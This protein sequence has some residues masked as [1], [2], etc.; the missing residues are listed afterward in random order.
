M[1]RDFVF[2]IVN[3]IPFIYFLPKYSVFLRKNA[4]SWKK[5]IY[6]LNHKVGKEESEESGKNQ[7]KWRKVGEGLSWI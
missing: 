4:V 1:T 5:N 6:N 2:I 3:E 7:E